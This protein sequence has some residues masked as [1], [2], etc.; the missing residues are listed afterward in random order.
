MAGI[1]TARPDYVAH[2]RAI[3]ATFP[4]VVAQLRS[5]LGAKLCAYVGS[6]KETRAV[7]E[8]ADGSR[9]PSDD[10]QQRLRLALRIA[11]AISDTDGP[12][13]TRAWFQGLN[14]QLD[15]HSPARLLREGDLT[16]V[17]PAVIAAERAF[18]IGG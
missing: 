18:L 8:W 10:T 7:N 16:E 12:E 2:D 5:I 14:P 15:D 3:R 11:L 17:G 4:E 9:V 6:V 1:S 13:V